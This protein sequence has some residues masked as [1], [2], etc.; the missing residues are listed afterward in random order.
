MQK[1]SQHN[2]DEQTQFF[3]KIYLSHFIRKGYE[4][5][6][7][8]RWGG[9]WT[10][11]HHI[12]PQ[13]FWLLQRFFLILQGCST[14]GPEVPASVGTWFSLLELQQLTPNSDLQLTRT[15]C[16]TRLYNCLTSTCSSEHR[17]CTQPVH[18]QGYPL[19][20]ST[21]CTCNLHRCISYLTARHGRRSICYTLNSVMKCYKAQIIHS[22]HKDRNKV[23]L[24]TVVEGD[25]MA[26]F[27]ITTTSRFTNASLLN[28]S[29]RVYVCVSV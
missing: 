16:S 13:L 15:F 18:S 8:E 2:N 22:Q 11:L 25:P 23:K 26:P 28:T 19:I 7:C 5:V 1:H 17:I 24:V 6:M 3:R 4:R 20:S 14:G 12:D 27:S 10:K 9:D 21:G 29:V